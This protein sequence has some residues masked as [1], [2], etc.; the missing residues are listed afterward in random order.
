MNTLV[1]FPDPLSATLDVLRARVPALAAGV[2]FGTLRPE[3][4]KDGGP[5]LPYV[6]LSV[7]T[8]TGQYPVVSSA[9]VRVAVWG[10]SD[11]KGLDLARVCHAVLRA[12]EGDSKVRSFGQGTDPIPTSDPD[13][14]SPL[15]Y[16]TVSARLKPSPLA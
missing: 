13:S 16:F 14:G 12:Y 3:V 15:S 8:V 4:K 6:C 1:R 11:A 7:D 2:T 5:R 10:T 9:V